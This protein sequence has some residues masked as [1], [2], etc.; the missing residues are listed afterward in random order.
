MFDKRGFS[1]CIFSFRSVVLNLVPSSAF[2]QLHA[3]KKSIFVIHNITWVFS[4]V[5]WCICCK[6]FYFFFP[7]FPLTLAVQAASFFPVFSCIQQQQMAQ[8]KRKHRLEEFKCRRCTYHKHKLIRTCG[9]TNVL[10]PPPFFAGAFDPLLF[11]LS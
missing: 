8:E 1:G 5:Q 9:F 2:Q 10:S 4:F 11:S 3:I 7:F 6:I